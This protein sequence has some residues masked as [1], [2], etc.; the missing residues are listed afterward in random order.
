MG[1]IQKKWTEIKLNFG[2]SES[3]IYEAGRLKE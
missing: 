1:L 3:R 2:K